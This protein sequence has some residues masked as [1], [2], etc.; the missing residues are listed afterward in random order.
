MS[1]ESQR[2]LVERF[3]SGTGASYRRTATLGT[4][5][6]DL[7]WK[8]RIVAAVPPESG[9]ILDQASG[10]GILTFLLARRFPRGLVLGVELRREYALIAQREKERRRADNV[11]FVQGRAEDVA[12]RPPVDCIASSYLAKYADLDAL[13]ANARGMLRPGGVILLH[14]FTYPTR[15]PLGKL[16]ELYLSLLGAAWGRAYPEWRE[17]L[18]GLPGLVRRTD[19]VT[20]AVGALGRQ[21]FE[22]IAVRSLTVGAAALVS[23]RRGSTPPPGR[24]G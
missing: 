16:W 10:T 24:G 19:W 18:D 23:A 1:R 21:G 13:A 3:F 2:E 22:H 20:A 9:R 14:D 12:V 17:A 4:L 11:H 5:G 15:R 6:L 7:W 8:R